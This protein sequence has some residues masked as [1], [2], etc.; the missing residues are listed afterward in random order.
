MSRERSADPFSAFLNA[1]NR[2]S[3]HQ[4]MSRGDS[5]EPLPPIA[6]TALEAL[7]D[8]ERTPVDELRLT[9]GLTTRRIADLVT[10]LNRLGLIEIHQDGIDEELE[11][12]ARGRALL[13]A[14]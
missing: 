10:M 1:T 3:A 7:L 4:A 14:P 11:L 12:T 5:T 6:R 2:Q 13:A 8:R 9:L